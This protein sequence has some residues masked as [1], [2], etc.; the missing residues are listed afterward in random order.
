MHALEKEMQEKARKGNSLQYAWLE[1]PRDRGAWWAAIYGSH[2][3]GH[4]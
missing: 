2:R 4:D 1:N 3:V